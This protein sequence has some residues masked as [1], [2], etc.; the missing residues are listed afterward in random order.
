MQ[1]R[2]AFRKLVWSGWLLLM[3]LDP[4]NNVVRR[5]T[6]GL[7]LAGQNGSINS[8]KKKRDS[9]LFRSSRSCDLV[10]VRRSNQQ[11]CCKTIRARLPHERE[12]ATTSPSS[13]L[14]MCR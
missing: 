2:H 9:L 14:T 10:L 1:D 13:S 7:D 3:E 6:C 12:N 5:Y 8:L 4:N 11:P